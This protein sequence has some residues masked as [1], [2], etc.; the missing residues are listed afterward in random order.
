MIHRY[1]ERQ[2]KIAEAKGRPAS[3]HLI[4]SSEMFESV[5]ESGE[6]DSPESD[7]S[8]SDISGLDTSEP[9]SSE[10]PRPDSDKVESEQI[11]VA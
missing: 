5:E 8:V 7:I 4:D 3:W 2:D 1:L 10:S 6:T 11:K 9:D